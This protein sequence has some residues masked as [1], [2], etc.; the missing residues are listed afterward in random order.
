M[1]STDEHVPGEEWAETGQR[2]PEETEPGS[3]L[4]SGTSKAMVSGAALWRQQVSAMAWV[5]FLKLKG[6][7]KNLR[8]M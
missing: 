5:H 6:S 8:S 1:C 3:L 2:C 7:V 4:L